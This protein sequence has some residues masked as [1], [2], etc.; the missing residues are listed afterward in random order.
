METRNVNDVTSHQQTPVTNTSSL[1]DE[2]GHNKRRLLVSN[3]TA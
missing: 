3:A 2:R 1:L